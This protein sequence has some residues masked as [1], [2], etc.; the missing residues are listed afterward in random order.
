M[1]AHGH[2]AS[3][4]RT[5]IVVSGSLLTW[6]THG[7]KTKSRL[8]SV[9]VLQFL[10]RSDEMGEPQVTLQPLSPL[11]DEVTSLTKSS[12]SRKQHIERLLGSFLKGTYSF[13]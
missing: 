5:V 9:S 6:H 13:V 11:P 4:S 12:K 3:F 8:T 10:Y 7:I 1:T 2:F